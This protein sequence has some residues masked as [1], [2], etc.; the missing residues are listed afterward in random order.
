MN[1]VSSP[2]NISSPTTMTMAMADAPPELDP[3]V[4]KST[5]G[6]QDDGEE[7]RHHHPEDDPR[8]L[9]DEQQQHEA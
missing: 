7:R 9:P 3:V 2:A 4:E 8:E 5:A 6:R 1:A